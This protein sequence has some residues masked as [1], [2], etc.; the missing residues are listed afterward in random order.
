MCLYASTTPAVNVTCLMW[1]HRGTWHCHVNVCSWV[2]TPPIIANQQRSQLLAEGEK[3][4]E[5]MILNLNPAGALMLLSAQIRMP[6]LAE[7]KLGYSSS[8]LSPRRIHLTQVSHVLFSR[9]HNHG[10]L[11][12][13]VF[14]QRRKNGGLWK[15][16]PF[17]WGTEWKSRD[18]ILG[19]FKESNR[20][21]IQT[22]LTTLRGSF[23]CVCVCGHI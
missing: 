21:R 13:E 1:K 18:N 14:W 6:Q 3:K 17:G 22:V 16:W 8:L 2:N 11:V 15:M 12:M 7:P 5:K 19:Q 4:W 23:K 20:I 9:P 10:H